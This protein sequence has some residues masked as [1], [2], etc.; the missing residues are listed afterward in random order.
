MA[1]LRQD[2]ASASGRF[3]TK[4]KALTQSTNRNA[5]DVAYPFG[6]HLLSKKTRSTIDK[7]NKTA[8]SLIRL[9]K[10][11]IEPLPD[12]TPTTPRRTTRRARR[13]VAARAR[14]KLPSPRAGKHSGDD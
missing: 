6:N 7:R 3:A 2:R 12:A 1:Q 4:D 13:A 11:P 10:L 9:S 14:A 5:I 8:C